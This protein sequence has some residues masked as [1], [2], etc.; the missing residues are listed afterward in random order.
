MSK[1]NLSVFYFIRNMQKGTT[2]RRVDNN[3]GTRFYAYV[4]ANNK[5]VFV[6]ISQHEYNMI[7][8]HFNVIKSCF[9]TYHKNAKLYQEHSIQ[10]KR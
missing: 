4:N 3:G 7:D 9:S 6:R 1:E 10:F 2:L 8:E 5:G